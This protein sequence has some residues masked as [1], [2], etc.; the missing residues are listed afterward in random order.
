MEKFMESEEII[1]HNFEVDVERVLSNVLKNKEEFNLPIAYSH[2][3]KF[4]NSFKELL[5]K[6]KY[7]KTATIKDE[8]Y[9]TCDRYTLKNKNLYLIYDD[10][11]LPKEIM[12]GVVEHI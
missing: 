9:G 3:I 2:D 8:G 11:S 12:I 6:N 5:K 1:L 4:T 10:T 7:K